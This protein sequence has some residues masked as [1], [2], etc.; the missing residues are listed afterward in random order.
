MKK[1]RN[2]IILLIVIISIIILGIIFISVQQKEREIT[3][4]NESIEIMQQ[5][6]TLEESNKV[7]EIDEYLEIK[8][9]I[10]SYLNELN[11]DSSAYYGYDESG[12]Y[13][14]LASDNDNNSSIINL[15]SDEYVKKNSIE[16]S[17]VR[18][19]TYKIE[20][21]CFFIPVEI[22]N[23]GNTDNVKSF[24]VYGLVENQEFVP[25]FESYLIIN[26][27]KNN[28]T[29]SIEQLNSKDEVYNVKVNVPS[30]IIE[31]DNNVFSEV[32]VTQEDLIHEYIND[33]KRLAFG[34]P[35]KLYNSFLDK[36]YKNRKFG[37]LDEFKKYISENRD[38][39]E[40]INPEKYQISEYEGYIQ[41]YII[42]QNN[43]EYV[44]NVKT[45]MDYKIMLDVYTIDLPQFTEKYKTATSQEKVALNI[46]KF[47]QAINA[48]DYKYAY[49]CLAD[50]FRNNYFK[51]QADFE[52]YAKENFYS[53][54]TV[55]Y[56]QF[57]TQGEYY[58]YSIVLTNKE[59]EEQKNKTFIMQLG[60]G[61]D[62]KLSFNR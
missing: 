43:K 44:F 5:E 53:R 38:E 28:R 29:Y 54:N 21:D 26:I 27:D 47:M 34:Y 30:E 33:L 42:D 7:M 12:N 35:E 19:Y 11:I 18:N 56:N 13:V 41:Y 20:S 36:E 4:T 51:T 60:E 8:K 16:L 37:N 39:I 52:N 46:D 32:G 55:G 24:G 48:K 31:K 9:C 3:E 25:M 2:I 45:P 62:F 23:K 6:T 14:N 58:T 61:T 15:L 40:G 22:V 10:G 17:N 57:D 49:N 1:I 59:T 50:S